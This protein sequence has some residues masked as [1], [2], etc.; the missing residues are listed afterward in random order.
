MRKENP[1]SIH[2][3]RNEFEVL[4]F[5][6]RRQRLTELCRLP[7]SLVRNCLNQRPLILFDTHT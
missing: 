5:N 3:V 2:F 6:T 4:D 1:G 7:E